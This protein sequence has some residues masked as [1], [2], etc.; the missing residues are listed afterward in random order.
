MNKLTEQELIE[1]TVIYGNSHNSCRAAK[2]L[3]EARAELAEL[4]SLPASG[5][6][7]LK[8]GVA[9][10]C[11]LREPPMSDPYWESRGFSCE[12]LFTAAKPTE[13]KCS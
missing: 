7:W 11:L 3:L 6:L 1:P 10:N 12:P 2:E 4:K 8:D 13:D 9:I 5:Y